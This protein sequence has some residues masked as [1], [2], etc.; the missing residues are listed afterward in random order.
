MAKRSTI[1]RNSITIGINLSC[2][3]KTLFALNPRGA[4]QVGIGTGT[5]LNPVGCCIREMQIRGEPLQKGS[6]TKTS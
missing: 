4:L 5:E 2:Y 3:R 1:Q 6:P